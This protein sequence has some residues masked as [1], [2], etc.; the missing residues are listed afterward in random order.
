MECS[1]R[2]S[3]T[4]FLSWCLE[5]HMLGADFTKIKEDK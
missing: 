1:G 3:Q 2:A 5:E 4:T